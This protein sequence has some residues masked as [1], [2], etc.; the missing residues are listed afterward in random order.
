MAIVMELRVLT[1]SG[2]NTSVYK[3]ITGSDYVLLSVRRQVFAWVIADL[4][5]TGPL[6]SVD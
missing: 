4:L 5:S 1:H 3:V 2:I 6:E